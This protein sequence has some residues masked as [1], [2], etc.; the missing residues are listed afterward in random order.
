MQFIEPAVCYP[1]P[2]LLDWHETSTAAMQ[3]L[4]L[5]QR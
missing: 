5:V 4:V 2:R 1:S 3:P